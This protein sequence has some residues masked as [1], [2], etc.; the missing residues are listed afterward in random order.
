[1]KFFIA[2]FLGT[3]FLVPL[4]RVIFDFTGYIGFALEFVAI[5]AFF[6]GYRISHRPIGFIQPIPPELQSTPDFSREETTG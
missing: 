5:C 6:L 4:G 1:M 3:I 2:V